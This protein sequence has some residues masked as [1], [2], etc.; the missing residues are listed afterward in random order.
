[1][2]SRKPRLILAPEARADL[3][4]VLLH[5]QQHWGRQ[6]RATY[7]ATLYRTFDELRRFPAL[8]RT[9]SDYGGD[10]RSV[11]VGQ[12]V[13]IYE[14]TDSELRVVRILHARRDIGG[15]REG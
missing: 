14:A 13:V 3:R 1:M 11:P 7:R 12:H 2:S 10:V 8:G 6:Q 4:D 15:E 9:R 5:T